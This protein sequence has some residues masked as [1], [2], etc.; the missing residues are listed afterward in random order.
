MMNIRQTQIAYPMLVKGW[1]TLILKALNFFQINHGHQSF[2]LFEI[3]INVLVSFFDSF[4]YLC[5]GV[6]AIINIFTLTVRGSTL[7]G[8][9]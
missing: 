4:E 9:I 8:R 2:F 5:Y 1:T 3:I 6:T 7:E